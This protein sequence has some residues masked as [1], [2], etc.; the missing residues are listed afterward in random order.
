MHLRVLITGGNAGVARVDTMR[1]SS[2]ITGPQ[3]V[4][5][6]RFQIGPDRRW[7]PVAKGRTSRPGGEDSAEDRAPGRNGP[8]WTDFLIEG[9]NRAADSAPYPLCNLSPALLPRQIRPAH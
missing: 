2:G 1:K 9:R 7:V 5:G 8:H 3:V 4:Y 6:G